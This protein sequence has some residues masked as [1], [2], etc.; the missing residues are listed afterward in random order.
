MKKLYLIS[1][2]SLLIAVSCTYTS[3]EKYIVEG[4]K[5]NVTIR[6]RS[7]NDD[8]KLEKNLKE[9]FVEKLPVI[10]DMKQ[11]AYIMMLRMFIEINISYIGN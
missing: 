6:Y 3:Y 4:D 5:T 2:I 8:R 10:I 9:I 7:L 11:S 1:L